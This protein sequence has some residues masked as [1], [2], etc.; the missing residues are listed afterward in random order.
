MGIS[1]RTLQDWR[2]RL[3]RDS[4]AT[5]KLGRPPVALNPDTEEFLEDFLRGVG[6]DIGMP[7]LRGLM[8]WAAPAALE[9]RLLA[10]RRSHRR[11]RRA[12]LYRLTWKRAGSV[13]AVDLAQPPRPVDGWGRVVLAVRDLGS[14]Q[15]LA[16]APLP[17]GRAEDVARAIGR[18]FRRHSG[19]LILKSDNGSCFTAPRFRT[20]LARFGVVHLRSPRAWPQYNG[21]CEA[22]IGL[23]GALTNTLAAG[24]GREDRWS[25][26]DLEEAR[27]RANRF[28]RYRGSRLVAA[29]KLWSR[30]TAVR[31]ADRRRFRVV[32]RRSLES[33]R[34]AN[35]KHR[36]RRT[37]LK[38]KAVQQALQKLGYLT[39]R[40][41]W[42]RA[43]KLRRGFSPRRA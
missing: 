8:P 13:W 14:G 28:P 37:W 26:E 41:G 27:E 29:G 31:P 20:L 34:Q 10:Y 42:V 18:L 40:S 23:L 19:P 33:L 3:Q 32:L 5:R 24:Q 22:G 15:T 17:R 6:P 9:R 12:R 35:P 43:R 1:R 36:R 25:Q 11:R 16:W 30:R 4:A 2:R 7:T 39:I 38:R 21:A